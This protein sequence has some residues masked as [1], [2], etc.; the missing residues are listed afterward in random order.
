MDIANKIPLLTRRI[1]RKIQ[2]RYFRLVFI[3]PD[4]WIRKSLRKGSI[5]IDCGIG[6][7]ADF[8]QNLIE[9]YG[10]MCY[11]FDP[12][13]KHQAAISKIVEKYD[14]LFKY[15]QVAISSTAKEKIFYESKLNVSGS[16]LNDHV[17]VIQDDIVSYTSETV[18][19]DGLFEYIGSDF[20]DLLKL[21]IEGEEFSVLSTVSDSTL[22]RIGQLIVEFHHHCI[23]RYSNEDT[24]RLVQRLKGTGFRSFTDDGKN[25]LFFRT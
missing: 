17:N 24:H 21:D 11:G 6:D 9:R 22:F 7:N 23:D 25:Y 14:G 13:Q 4:Y 2:Q 20:L 16:F 5:A 19:L 10:I 3:G 15:Y 8:S 1:I 18:T 12:T